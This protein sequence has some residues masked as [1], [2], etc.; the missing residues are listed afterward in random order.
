ME[1]FCV[2]RPA[3]KDKAI[4]EGY[5]PVIN[6][7]RPQYREN[8]RFLALRM[9]QQVLLTIRHKKNPMLSQIVE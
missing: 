4:A 3:N 6:F 8:I 2:V 1:I 5:Y 7:H 9:I